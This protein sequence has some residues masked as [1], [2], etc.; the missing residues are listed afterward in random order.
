MGERES[1]CVGGDGSPHF[2]SQ[3]WVAASPT[4][5]YS[6]KGKVLGARETK[7]GHETTKLVVV[8]VPGRLQAA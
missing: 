5:G 6:N 8:K 7:P 1:G 3:P 2:E 4:R